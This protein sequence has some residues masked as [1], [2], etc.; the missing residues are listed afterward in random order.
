MED[1]INQPSTPL[2]DSGEPGKPPA[3][4]DVQESYTAVE[5]IGWTMNFRMQLLNFK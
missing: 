3:I 5:G 4:V 1:K 2:K